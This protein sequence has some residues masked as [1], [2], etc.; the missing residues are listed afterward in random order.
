MCPARDEPG[1]V[2]GALVTEIYSVGPDHD[3]QRSGTS[4]SGVRGPAQRSVLSRRRH[5]LDPHELT[6]AMIHRLRRNKAGRR[7][8]ETL[9]VIEK[10]MAQ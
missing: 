3:G 10:A 8:L 2:G 6:D 5:A 4:R 9:T 1:R 7:S